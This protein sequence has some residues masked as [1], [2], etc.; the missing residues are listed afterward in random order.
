MFVKQYHHL[1][2]ILELKTNY[3]KLNLSNKPF[4]NHTNPIMKTLSM[5]RAKEAPSANTP[6]CQMRVVAHK[7]K[8]NFAFE[9][10][11]A[12]I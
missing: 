12:T 9:L 7:I 2:Y 6:T 11:N 8:W 1:F 5:F 10:K 4:Q 3:I